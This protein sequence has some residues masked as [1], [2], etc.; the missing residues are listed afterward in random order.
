MA[1]PS[2]IMPTKQ[3]SRRPSSLA[4][5]ASTTTTSA[6][7][8]AR[9]CGGGGGGLLHWT[10][11]RFLGWKVNGTP[12]TPVGA[13]RAGDRCRVLPRCGHRFHAECVDS[14]L[15]KSR[16][17]YVCRA[18]AVLQRKH[19]GAVAEAATTVEVVTESGR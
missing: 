6:M 17:C 15:R 9:A 14:W 7:T 2:F 10:A 8:A 19:A 4:T 11:P 12:S 13:F 3:P 18:E 1:T 5:L 16:R